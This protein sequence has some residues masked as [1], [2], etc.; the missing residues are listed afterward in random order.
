MTSP[1]DAVADLERIMQ[2]QLEAH[3][4]LRDCIERSREALRTADMAAIEADCKQQHD[5]A[6]RVAELEKTRL[7]VVGRLTETLSPGAD[8]PLTVTQIA[9][10]L[11]DPQHRRLVA[12][13][14]ELRG[15]VEDVR[16]SSSIVRIAAESLSCHMSGLMQS[17][18]TALS[19][20]QLY[21][22]RGRLAT[23]TRKQLC[24]DVT[25]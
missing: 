19:R 5:A 16:K 10:R 8:A 14:D 4:H 25:S 13:A 23:D 21:G 18:H 24:I 9:E 6:Q 1:P 3:R 17:V 12:L 7:V 15:V 22:R 2:C 20:V 11:D